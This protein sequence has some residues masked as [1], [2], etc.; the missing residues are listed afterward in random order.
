MVTP[1]DEATNGKHTRFK[2]YGHPCT[3]VHKRT[4]SAIDVG[5]PEER[6]VKTDEGERLENLPNPWGHIEKAEVPRAKIG[7]DEVAAIGKVITRGYLA[8]TGARDGRPTTVSTGYV[9]GEK[10]ICVAECVIE[11][12]SF[13]ASPI[14]LGGVCT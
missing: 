9:A 4:E 10:T 7:S 1:I 14:R 6:D 5:L 12:G 13:T 11:E 8:A 2:R 3:L